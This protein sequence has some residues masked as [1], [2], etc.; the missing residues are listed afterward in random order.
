M[1][2]LFTK[3]GAE[4]NPEVVRDTCRLAKS[5]AESLKELKNKYGTKY[6]GVLEP[7]AP[8]DENEMK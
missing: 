2:A 5:K 3:Y 4:G 8:F 7:G 6:S 1:V